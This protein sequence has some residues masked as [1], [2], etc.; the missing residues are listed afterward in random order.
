MKE[1]AADTEVG[2]SRPPIIR[3][4]RR[5]LVNEFAVWKP[6]TGGW[7][8]LYG[9]F[10]ELGV[11]I[12]WHDFETATGLD[13]ARS[14]HAD[15]LEICLNLEGWGSVRTGTSSVDFGPRTAG[16][17][18]QHGNELRASRQSGQRHR[19]VTIEVSADFL[20]G[21]LSQSD[22]ALHP[23]VERYVGG[24]S[25]AAGISER[26]SLGTEEERWVRE[27]TEPPTAQA[28]R[29]LWYQGRVLQLMADFFFERRDA[30]ELFGD[31]QKRLARERVSRVVN[32]LARNLV[33]P[34]S[35]EEI[36]REVGCS[37]FHL[38]RTF[39]K[40]TGRTIPQYLRKLRMERAAELLRS[41]KYN[42][43]EAALEVGYSSLSHFSQAFCQTMGCCPG[44]Y[45][46]KTPT[47]VAAS[48]RCGGTIGK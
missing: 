11:A 1:T 30:D 8:R 36:G 28:A 48:L 13:W 21:H 33:E 47:Q 20:R 4:Q 15:G 38:S 14:F 23:L 2:Q 45:P 35:L 6:F 32:L 43:T 34:L 40:E 44:L 3:P 29:R 10:Y 31:R 22:G 42:V 5:S 12:E 37:P 16:F 39:S 25:R 19:F 46:L 18:V 24:G 41:G 27:L 9:S 17:Y 7:R 26:R